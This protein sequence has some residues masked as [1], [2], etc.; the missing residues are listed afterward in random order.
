[1]NIQLLIKNLDRD[2]SNGQTFERLDPM[3]G[4][5]A[6]CAA[7]ATVADAEA[8][9]EA[10]REAFPAWSELGPNARR[11]FL[12]KAADLMDQRVPDFTR[13]MMTETGATA[14][15][16]GFNV[17]LAA[18]MLRE[19]ASMTTQVAGEVIPS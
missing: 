18:S 11:A 14:G 17:K 15:W 5:V 7:A 16:A 12:L 1:M 3:T 4:Q 10:A 6:T 19:A 9:C 13:L 8:A 2:A